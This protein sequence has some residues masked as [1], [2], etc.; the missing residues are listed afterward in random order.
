MVRAFIT[1]KISAAR[2]S[3]DIESFVHPNLTSLEHQRGT[4]LGIDSW[5]DTNCAGKHAYV[6]EFVVDKF[7]TA[8]GFSA[9]LGTI[10]DLPIAN[11][12]Y[13]YDNDEGK[14]YIIECNNSI[15]LG[16]RMD[17]S[18]VNP[19]QAEESDVR[20]DVRPKRY[21]SDPHAQTIT[22]PCG[23]VL[24]GEYDG[25]LPF[26]P[27][28]RPT[29][30]E[31]H[32]CQ[33][34]V[35]SAKF[36]WDPS[37]PGGNFSQPR[38]VFSTSSSILD[39]VQDDPVGSSLMSLHLLS[40]VQSNSILYPYEDSFKSLHAMNSYKSKESISPE[41][42]AR[43]LK[44]GLKTAQRTLQATTSK[45]IRTT[46]ALTRRFKTDKAQ[47]RYKQLSRIFG[48]FYCDY[49]KV[50]ATSIRGYKGGVVYTTGLGFYKFIQCKHETSETT[51]PTLRYFLHVIGLPYS[52][53]SDN[54]GNFKDGLF[55]RLMRKFGI[56]QTFTELH[57]PWQNRAEP[58]IGEVKKYARKIMIS[59]DT[60][61]RLW[62]FCYEYTADLL[63][64]LA[65]GRFDLQGRTP[66]EMI[67]HYTPDIS[68]YVSFGWFQWCYYFNE[69]SKSK[70]I[71]CWLAPA[72]EVG[73][74][75][76]HWVL[77][78]NGSF[79]ARSSVIPIPEHELESEDLK[80]LHDAFDDPIEDDEPQ[81]P[82]GEEVH[83]AELENVDDRYLEALD[84]YINAE[85]I[86]PE[87]DG[88]A[89]LTKVKGRKRDAEGNPVG[90][91]NEN[92]ILDTRVYQLQ[93][94][95]GR[96]EEYAVN[97]IAENL[98]EQ[99]DENSWDS[100]I[101]EE[102]LDIRKDD[103]V[104]VPKEQGMYFNAAGVERNVV[105][106]KGWEVQVKWRDKSTSWISL[107][108]AKEG[109]PLGLAEL[110]VA[111]KSNVIRKGKTKFG[112]QIPGTWKEAVGIDDTNGNRLWQDAIE[113]EMANAKC[114]LKLL[115]R[116]DRP[117]PGYNEILCHLVFDVKLDMTRKARDVAGG[118]LTDV[119]ANMTYSSVVS[120]DT[121][122]IGFLVAA[123]N[124]LD[125]LAGDIQNAFL[126][127]PTEEKIFF[128]AG[129]EWGADK[130]RV[131]V[132][133]RAL[134]GLK[135]SALQFRNHLAATL[136]NKLGFKSCLADPDLWY[137]ACIDAD[138]NEYY[139][140]I[141]VY[142]DDLLIIDKNPKRFMEK[143][144]GDFTVKKE[145]IGPPDRYLGA[146]IRKVEDDGSKPFWTMSSNSYLDKAIKNLKAKLKESGLEY[147]KKLSDPNYSPKQPFTTASY[148]PELDTSEE[149]T[150]DQVTLFQNLIGIMRWAVELGRIDIGYEV[151]V[152]SRYL[153]SPR[154]GHLLQAIH[155]FKFLDIHKDK[156]LAFKPDVPN[157]AFNYDKIKEQT[158][159]MKKAYPD[160]VEVLPPNAPTPRGKSLSMYVFVDSDHA[161]DTVTRRSQTGITGIILYLNS[162]PI[163][164]YSKRQATVESSTFG[165]EFVALRVA[166]ELIISMRY[167]LHMMG[168]PI[169]GPTHIFC[170]NEAVY[171]NS[172]IA[173]STLKKKHNSI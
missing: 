171:K 113:K 76:C 146:D 40:A 20:V 101:I 164:W 25:A 160:A 155:M 72:H 61:I 152:L 86:L 151:S 65:T 108:D 48:K 153:V 116:G 59:T 58:A 83:K 145:S 100:G 136:G 27:I 121:V 96:V 168:V 120:R 51:G 111:L 63:S 112:I 78:S 8:G 173:H 85:V 47:L 33:R 17:D 119:P 172:S 60:P 94:P 162:A 90:K 7:V 125:I 66:Y 163:I 64:L 99:A 28:R 82:Y 62:C 126:S 102:F 161:G 23:T 70:K 21:Y 148:K 30:D 118:H 14:I 77:L 110:A 5:A 75:F 68:E 122:R 35:L 158:E 137:K 157:L 46:G 147:N 69:D 37:I 39:L 79:I 16:D 53:H 165:S 13:A 130:D 123:L 140:Y 104:A 11:G 103:S 4:R 80:H 95:D 36:P 50:K 124:D 114:A 93:F 129:D 84:N 22:F 144:Q 89:V 81:L 45:F 55:K 98:F 135:S 92:P 106:T 132:V 32:S 105:T 57:S 167:K 71:C 15:Y 159:Y 38:S 1:T 166:S 67:M 56:Y 133:V 73:Q 44:I 18:L 115:A 141:L 41:E 109:D 42:M 139:A 170:D 9:S 138:G 128:Y 127:A 54:H 143:I 142:V 19:I 107:K 134:Y 131:V 117:P 169:E 91:A 97:M 29:A 2:T 3:F 74:S 24:P 43:L 150:D 88:T 156:E 154:T 87:K 6:E 10:P 26:I 34:L 12:L 49:L 52:L 149:C 31:I